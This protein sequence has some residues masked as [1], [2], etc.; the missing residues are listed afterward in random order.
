MLA[1]FKSR[2]VSTCFLCSPACKAKVPSSVVS[3]P[4]AQVSQ[5]SWGAAIQSTRLR[6]SKSAGWLALLSLTTRWIHSK[7]SFLN[8]DC[9]KRG[10]AD[11]PEL[12]VCACRETAVRRQEAL[13][14][15]S[16]MQMVKPPKSEL[17]LWMFSALKVGQSRWLPETNSL[18]WSRKNDRTVIEGES[19]GDDGRELGVHF[20]RQPVTLLYSFSCTFLKSC[21]GGRSKLNYIWWYGRPTFDFQTSMYDVTDYLSSEFR[22]NFLNIQ[23]IYVWN[24]LILKSI[25]ISTVFFFTALLSFIFFYS[26]CCL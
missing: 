20:Y 16:K 25:F 1:A 2:V 24:V 4:A 17:V 5:H 26:A 18:V 11:R 10:A 8:E 9:S 12:R 14:L 23:C 19:D 7:C 21:W 6:V 3:I 15:V 13:W 22:F